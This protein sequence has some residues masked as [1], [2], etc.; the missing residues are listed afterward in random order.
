MIPAPTPISEATSRLR[1]STRWSKNDIFPPASSSAACS[2]GALRLGEFRHRSVTRDCA[3]SSSS[4]RICMLEL[5]FCRNGFCGRRLG[6]GSFGRGRPRHGKRV[7]YGRANSQVRRRGRH[8]A[9]AP[10]ALKPRLPLPRRR[11]VSDL[12]VATEQATDRV[13]WQS[14]RDAALVGFAFEIPKMA[15]EGRAQIA[16]SPA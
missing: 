4:W 15:F 6:R 16:R 11:R 7:G 9:A 12:A 1:S 3:P 10:S 13:G 2:A 8:R 14:V 5:R